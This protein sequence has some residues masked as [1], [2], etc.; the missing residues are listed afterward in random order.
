MNDAEK[1][2]VK[3]GRSP[4]YPGLDIESALQRARELYAKLQR[5]QTNVVLAVGHWGYKFGTGAS[6]VTLA[7]LKKYGFLEEEGSGQHRKVFLTELAERIIIDDR[8]NSQDRD[9]LI[10][11]AALKPKIH[12]NLFDKYEYSLPPD[13]NIIYDL[14]SDQKFTESGARE[15][16]SQ[17][18]RTLVFIQNLKSDKISSNIGDKGQDHGGIKPPFNPPPKYTPKNP[19]GEGGNVQTIQIPILEGTWP[20]ITAQFPM[21]EDDWTYMMGVLTTM[22]PKLVKPDEIKP[23]VDDNS[24]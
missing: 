14:R 10:I 7:S 24:E 21:T 9:K 11:E 12:E 20:S 16:V 2:K 23:E 19:Q 17:Y 15:L 6:N 3:K 22:K 5:H 8:P 1:T 13:E 18:R 4:S